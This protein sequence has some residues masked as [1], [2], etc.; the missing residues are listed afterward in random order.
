MIDYAKLQLPAEVGTRLLHHQLLSFRR[1]VDEQTGEVTDTDARCAI[2]RGLTFTNYPSGRTTMHGSFHKYWHGGAN[3]CDYTFTQFAAT[4]DELCTTF[5]LDPYTL[6]LLQLEAGANIEPQLP[7]LRVLDAIVCSGP[8]IELER[9]RWFQRRVFARKAMRCEYT[10]KVYDKGTEY[11]LE[12]KVLRCEV[13]F[14]KARQFQNLGIF[15]VGDLLNPDAWQRLQARVMDIFDEL[16][17]AEPSID[18]TSLNTTQRTFVTLATAPAYWKGLTKG[19]RFKA[20]ARYAD[21][22]ERFAGS[23][24]KDELRTRLVH[25]LKDL[26]NTTS[27]AVQIGDPFT[28]IPAGISVAT[29]RPFHGSVNVGTRHPV[30]AGNDGRIA[31]VTDGSDPWRNSATVTR[32][33]ATV[34]HRC[35]TCGRDITDQRKGS[36]YC[37]EARYSNAGKRCR[38]AGSNPKNNRLR[39]LERIERDPLLFDHG[40]FITR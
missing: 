4:V 20:R 8:G 21:I 17:I 2:Y 10:T 11:H 39:S 7:T 5:D 1:P 22:V 9:H 27:Q 6:R 24:L 12:R 26:L 28:D 15:T 18:P 37:S 16:F 14:D 29:G 23:D 3:W 33:G 40:P 30:E 19:D 36:R 38:N 31:V 25:K 34:E 32:S 13:H 35:L